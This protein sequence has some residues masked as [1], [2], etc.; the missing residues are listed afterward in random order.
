MKQF[1]SLRAFLRER[2]HLRRQQKTLVFT[3]GTFDILHRGHVDYLAKARALGDALIVGLNTDASIRRIKGPQRPINSQTDRARVLSALA[4]VDYVVLFGDDTPKRLI[5]KILPDV[6]VKGADWKVDDI[7]GKDI[8][9]RNGGVVK[10]IRLTRDR[11]TTNVIQ[12][13]LQAYRRRK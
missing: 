4:A 3:N 5:E 11:S 1:V 10:T 12:R 2:A 7:V 8:V 6:L 9:E 13:V